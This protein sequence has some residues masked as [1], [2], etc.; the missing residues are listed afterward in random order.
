MRYMSELEPSAWY[1]LDP[2]KFQTGQSD[3]H[4][5][6]TSDSDTWNRLTYGN[7]HKLSVHQ[8]DFFV[9]FVEI[10]EALTYTFAISI[11]VVTK[12]KMS[13]SF[14][15]LLTLSLKKNRAP[16]RLEAEWC[17]YNSVTFIP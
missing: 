1:V 4:T 9:V 17:I 10:S 7:K 12:L 2:S 11:F 5:R 6:E 14:S 8:F 16:T 15:L 3:T 13:L